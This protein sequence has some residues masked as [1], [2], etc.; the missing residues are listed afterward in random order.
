MAQDGEHVWHAPYDDCVLVMPGMNH[1]KPGNTMARLGRYDPPWWRGRCPGRFRAHALEHVQHRLRSFHRPLHGVQVATLHPADAP[2]SQGT[3]HGH[4]DLASFR[5]SG[6]S[7][8]V[9][10]AGGGGA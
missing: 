3:R 8:V 10:R 9:H 6:A 4:A 7:Q 5:R 1:L 2:L